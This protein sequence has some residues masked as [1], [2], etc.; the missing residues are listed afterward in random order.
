MRFAEWIRDLVDALMRTP[1]LRSLEHAVECGET[2][3][4]ESLQWSIRLQQ[5]SEGRFENLRR[6]AE[7]LLLQQRQDL[8]ERL[9][10]KDSVISDLKVRLAIAETDAI[11]ERVEK[12]KRTAP[13]V[14]PDFGGPVSF[15]DE[16]AAMALEADETQEKN[17]DVS[18]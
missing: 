9:K 7:L 14:V 16:L 10:D 11:R 8:T 17:D 13:K 1:Y 12:Q 3:L 4:K 6:D 5:E 15:Q 2:E 18:R